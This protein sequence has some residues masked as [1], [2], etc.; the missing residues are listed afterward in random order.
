MKMSGNYPVICRTLQLCSGIR[1]T[2][3]MTRTIED[4]IRPHKK[5][6]IGQKTS[7]IHVFFFSF[8]ELGVKPARKM[9]RQNQQ[10]F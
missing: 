3:E 9:S 4:F 8:Q 5:V 2:I 6:G 10:L 1:G 7:D